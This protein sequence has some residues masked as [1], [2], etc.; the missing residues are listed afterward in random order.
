MGAATLFRG[1]AGRRAGGPFSILSR[2]VGAATRGGTVMSSRFQNFQYPQS[3]RGRCNCL[4]RFTRLSSQGSFSILSRIVGAA[5]DSA[6]LVVLALRYAFSILSRIV[7][8]AT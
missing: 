1:W 2:I 4:R 8:A 7:G 5:T 3:D 6:L